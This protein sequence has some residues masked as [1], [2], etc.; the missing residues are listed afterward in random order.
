M[1]YNRKIII[2]FD[3]SI[4]S[5][6]QQFFFF[7]WSFCLTFRLYQIDISEFLLFNNLIFILNL[8]K[9]IMANS[10]VSENVNK[11]LNVN[12]NKK[13]GS[14]NRKSDLKG[15]KKTQMRKPGVRR[16]SV[17]NQKLYFKWFDKQLK[18]Y[19]ETL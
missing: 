9:A 6:C 2:A 16:V 19:N 1:Q 8:F 12:K 14:P 15:K 11:N 7:V 10:K 5:R 13:E 18:N 3:V 4:Y 17:A